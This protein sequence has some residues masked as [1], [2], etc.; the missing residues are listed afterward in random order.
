M[1]TKPMITIITLIP[2]IAA[3]CYGYWET[4]REMSGYNFVYVLG[5]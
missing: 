4:S 5:G 3:F 1:K 2:I